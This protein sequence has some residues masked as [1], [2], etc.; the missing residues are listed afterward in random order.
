MYE[1]IER[2]AM[3]M[4]YLWHA[5]PPFFST[6]RFALAK[7]DTDDDAFV[8]LLHSQ[9]SIIQ[10]PVLDMMVSYSVSTLYIVTAIANAKERACNCWCVQAVKSHITATEHTR[11]RNGGSDSLVVLVFPSFKRWRRVKRK[12][13]KGERSIDSFES[14]I[15]DFSLWLSGSIQRTQI[16]AV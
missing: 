5:E 11:G 14:I 7:T 4:Y 10:R 2:N 13:E 12:M 1:L 3:R 8:S 16:A 9:A 6:P 15:N